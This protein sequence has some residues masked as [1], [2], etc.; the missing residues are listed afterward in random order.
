MNF[1]LGNNFNSPQGRDLHR[2]PISD[3][4]TW[5]KNSHQ[6]KFG[7]EWE[8]VNAVGY[9]GFFD[10]ARA[11]LLSPEFLASISPVLPALFGLPDGI[12]HTQDDLKKLPVAAF[13]LGIGDRVAAVVS[14]GGC[15]EQR[16]ISPL[17]AGQLEDHAEL[18]AEL[19][20]RL[21]ARDQR[22]QLRSARSRS[23]S[24]RSTAATSARRRRST[25]TSHRRP[26][27]P[28]RSAARTS[29]RR[30]RRRGPLLRHAA[31]VVAARRA[32]RA[33]RLRPSVH[34]QRGRDQPGHRPAVQHG[35]PQLARATTTARSC[36]AADAPSAAGREVS[37]HGRLAADSA[38]QAG[39][40]ARRAVP[41]RFP[42]DEREPLQ[43]RRPAPA[44]RR[45]VRARPTVVYRKGEHVRR[46]ADSSAP[47]ST[48]T[49]SMPSTA[50]S[51][52]A[53]RRPR[54]PTIRPRSARR[55]DQLLV[56]GRRRPSTRRCWSGSTSAS[57]IATSSPCRTRCRAARASRTSRRT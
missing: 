12:I 19:R 16:P 23:T 53:V 37:G 17:R 14:P 6:V 49:A 45:D 28:G 33:W 10:P 8:H 2:Y 18:H 52:R 38:L 56:A 50:R 11:Y 46:P 51:F 47:A 36:A 42:D 43:R 55:A 34:R 39:E 32:R 31:R 20:P 22:P 15:T 21:G 54:R 30:P 40:C 26:A 29:D 9:W 7:G 48:T 3:N 41:A 35:V 24:R 4:L 13:V 1:A 57:P 27:L 44:D 25:R 5:Q